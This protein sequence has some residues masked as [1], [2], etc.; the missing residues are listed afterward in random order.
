MRGWG[1]L[2]VRFYSLSSC[3][4]VTIITRVAAPPSL[5]VCNCW[6][7]RMSKI[8]SGLSSIFGLNRN[9]V[10]RSS[11]G[12]IESKVHCKESRIAGHIREMLALSNNEIRITIIPE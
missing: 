5:H 11:N 3:Y 8:R 4:F 9:V 7:V 2:F 12:V 10:I 1:K 6:G